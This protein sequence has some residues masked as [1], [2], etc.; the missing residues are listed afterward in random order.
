MLILVCKHSDYVLVLLSGSLEESRLAE[1]ESRLAEKQTELAKLITQR[2]ELMA[3]QK[4]LLKLQELSL[5]VLNV[6]S[7]LNTHNFYI[8][9]L[10]PANHFV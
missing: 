1:Y 9:H 7:F 10:E 8:V 2:N 6:L 3:T 5:Q 4:K